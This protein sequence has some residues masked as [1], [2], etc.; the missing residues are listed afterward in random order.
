[1]KT[2]ILKCEIII[3]SPERNDFHS[4]FL[5]CV[6]TID[7]FLQ[8]ANIL[9]QLAVLVAQVRVLSEQVLATI[10]TF[11]RASA[12]GMVCGMNASRPVAALWMQRASFAS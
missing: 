8:L 7:D 6:L 3:V 9:V 5:V 1:M 11:F 4:N 2:I 12:E 10:T